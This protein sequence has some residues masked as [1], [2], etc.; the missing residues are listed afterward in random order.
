MLTKKDF[1]LVEAWVTWDLFWGDVKGFSTKCEFKV[2]KSKSD[3]DILLNEDIIWLKRLER[4]WNSKRGYE[5]DGKYKT[6]QNFHLQTEIHIPFFQRKSLPLLIC[7]LQCLTFKLAMAMPFPCTKVLKL[8]FSLGSWRRE[9][10]N[11][12][13]YCFA[14][15]A[16]CVTHD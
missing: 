13:M 15:V 2:N 12:Q 6:D 7:P 11:Q 9:F 10:T 4:S 16:N 3:W 1:L 5:W 14:D 8:K